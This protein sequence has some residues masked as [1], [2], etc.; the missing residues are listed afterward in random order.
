MKKTTFLFLAG[1]I[2]L[3]AG[4][5]PSREKTVNKILSLEKRLFSSEAYSFDKV[6][7]DS[8]LVLYKGFIKDHPKDSLAP[9]YLFKAANIEMNMGDGGKAI[10]LF[11]Q[12]LQNYPDQKKA[13]MCLFFKGF[14]YENVLRDLDKARETYLLFIEKYPA[15]DFAKDAKMAL[16]NLGKTPDMLVKEFEVQR[17]ADSIRAVDSMA[18]TKK[19]RRK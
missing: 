1:I 16:K 3:M 6:K 5:S 13:P 10:G 19:T 9:G 11:D 12:Y 2:G 14:V 17:K 4:C 18:K 15:N 7:A 8:L